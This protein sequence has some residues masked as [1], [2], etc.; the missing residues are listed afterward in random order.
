M[1]TIA[2]NAFAQDPNLDAHGVEFE[3]PVWAQYYNLRFG[4]GYNDNV[5]RSRFVDQASPLSFAEFEAVVVRLP[6]NGFDFNVFLTGQ[7]IRYFGPGDS[8][9]DQSFIATTS[10]SQEIGKDWVVGLE[11]QYVYLDQVFDVSASLL[12]LGNIKSQLHQGAVTP[13]VRRKLPARSWLELDLQ[14]SRSEFL[15]PVEDE[16]EGGPTLTYGLDFG[17]RSDWGFSYGILRRVGDDF[18]AFDLTGGPITGTTIVR[19]QHEFEFRFRHYWDEAL[20]WRSS[21]KLE[22]QANRH[23][24]STFFDYDRFQISQEL[25]YR[26]EKWEISSKASFKFYNYVSRTVSPANPEKR[27]RNRLNV[28]SSLKRRIGKHW[29][30]F[31]RHELEFANSNRVS[32]DYT[33]NVVIG[34]IE[35]EY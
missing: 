15:A 3:D 25:R 33:A 21:T 9:K 11:S 23:N 7:D 14:L 26:D 32:D 20:R 24:G 5:L 18:N 17:R 4:G 2:A 27:K 31:A 29:I 10:L 13:T 30:L 12:D 1:S 8:D 35:W 28:E 19:K 16:W 6:R 22:A 34:G